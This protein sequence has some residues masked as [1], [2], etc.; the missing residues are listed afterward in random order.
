VTGLVTEAP[1]A[2]AFAGVDVR[3]P[4]GTQAL[5]DI[6][7]AV[8]RGEF[9]SLVGPSG[10]GKSTLL[11]L[12]A[13]L[14]QPTAG[15]VHDQSTELG[16]VFQDAT[17]LPWRTVAGNVGLL[18]QLRRLSRRERAERVAAAIDTV[19]LRGSEDKYPR[20]LSG[21]MRM[22]VSLARALTLDPDLFLFDEPFGALDEM[23]RER[24]NDEV[25]RL[26]GLKGFA[27]LFVTHSVQEATYLATRVV[28]LSSGP[29][30]VVADIGVD[31][32]Y[33]RPPSLR[34]DPSFNRIAAAVSD[35]L[36]S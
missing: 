11:R 7:L 21:G 35:A 30:R 18:P 24:L 2:V 12:A 14:Q 23:T 26:F 31:F 28:V 29:G 19:G 33:P 32:A 17:L 36:R 34:F 10:C 3:F 5:A 25:L 4:D 13:G 27:G 16:Y 8:R 9:V 1:P 20:M 15:S 6:D 22:R